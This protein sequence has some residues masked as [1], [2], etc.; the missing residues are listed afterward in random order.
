MASICSLLFVIALILAFFAIRER[1][2]RTRENQNRMQ[3]QTWGACESPPGVHSSSPPKRRWLTPSDPFLSAIPMS[4]VGSSNHKGTRLGDG[5]FTGSLRDTTT[6]SS[7]N[8]AGMSY[9]DLEREA[10]EERLDLGSP[11]SLLCPRHSV[12]AH[13]FDRSARLRRQEDIA[14]LRGKN[15]YSLFDTAHGNP[16][17]SSSL[18]PPPDFTT[19]TTTGQP[20]P[21]TTTSKTAEGWLHVR[22]SASSNFSVFSSDFGGKDDDGDLGQYVAMPDEVGLGDV[23][24]STLALVDI[25]QSTFGGEGASGSEWGGFA[26]E[27]QTALSTT[28]VVSAPRTPVEL[29][30]KRSRLDLDSD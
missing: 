27:S 1:I 7:S 17:I 19:T 18:S 29:V 8:D 4:H 13:H 16:S 30:G 21:S 10:R 24:P 5:P 25:S 9:A 2:R 6:I 14:H 12:V 15:I 28:V 11:P 22:R 23:V 20:S 3:T 26:G